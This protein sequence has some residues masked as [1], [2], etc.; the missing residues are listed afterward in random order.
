MGKK[1]IICEDE[2][3]FCIKNTSDYYCEECAQENFSDIDLLQKVE[4]QVRALKSYLEN[5]VADVHYVENE[6]IIDDTEDSGLDH[7]LT[8]EL[9][10]DSEKSD[11]K[12]KKESNN[13]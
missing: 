3:K 2:A 9:I 6:K 11:K 4:T 8:Q 1:C 5:K 13:S 7:G 12:E 10:E